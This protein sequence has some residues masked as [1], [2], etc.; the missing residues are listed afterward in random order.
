MY[1]VPILSEQRLQPE[2]LD[3]HLDVVAGA[4]EVPVQ[5]L[6]K[7]AEAILVEV[8]RRRGHRSPVR[9]E[10]LV[11]LTAEIRT[12]W[13]DVVEFHD[14]VPATKSHSSRGGCS[15]PAAKTE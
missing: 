8:E 7:L 10:V 5:P 11:Q 4:K 2:L 3:E 6:S 15:S 14:G 12:C 1:L 9:L 13:I